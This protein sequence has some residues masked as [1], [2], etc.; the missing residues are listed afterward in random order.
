[1]YL[2]LCQLCCTLCVCSGFCCCALLLGVLIEVFYCGLVLR[3]CLCCL[4]VP[5]PGSMCCTRPPLARNSRIIRALSSLV[6]FSGSLVALYHLSIF[7]SFL[8]GILR[9]PLLSFAPGVH[10]L[11]LCL[12]HLRDFR[13]IHGLVQCPYKCSLIL[14]AF[15]V[16]HC[17]YCIASR[18]QSQWFCLRVANA[19]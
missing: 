15:L 11:G 1:M 12:T 6:V 7:I 8:C 19:V 3:F 5:T 14:Y 9:L 18:A 13:F 17:V 10:T 4:S 2:R 16:A